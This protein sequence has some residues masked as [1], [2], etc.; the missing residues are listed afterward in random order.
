MAEL[1]LGA[2]RAVE[3]R[4]D[5]L[6]VVGQVGPPAVRIHVRFLAALLADEGLGVEPASVLVVD[7]H[8]FS[9]MKRGGSMLD[10][11]L[12]CDAFPVGRHFGALK[13]ER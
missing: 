11:W 7:R 13:T 10:V 9:L 6:L 3:D 12:E 2:G 8:G 4:P 5:L 1:T